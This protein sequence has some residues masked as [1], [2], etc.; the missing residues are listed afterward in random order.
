MAE[1][2]NNNT[3]PPPTD[4]TPTLIAKESGKEVFGLNNT[5][6]SDLYGKDFYYNI[7]P[8][9]V[10]EILSTGGGGEYICY[11]TSDDKLLFSGYLNDKNFGEQCHNYFF[12]YN[13]TFKEKYINENMTEL[14]EFKWK[15]F[16]NNKLTTT[17]KNDF[18]KIKKVYILNSGCVFMT[19][20]Q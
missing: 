12:K 11:W 10:K 6:N 14:F 16:I 1:K 17:I 7:L 5:I 15:D 20:F 2:P 9:K 18:T 8:F 13:L 19:L 3:T 4:S